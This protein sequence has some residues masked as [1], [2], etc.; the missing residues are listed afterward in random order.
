[1]KRDQ[2]LAAAIV[3]SLGARLD[4]IREIVGQGEVNYV[5]VARTSQGEWVVRVPRDPLD[6]DIYDKEAWC[7]GAAKRAGVS[8]PET[9]SFGA[10]ECVPF[11][12]QEFILGEL[13]DLRRSPALWQ[14][15]GEYAR[16]INEIEID[17]SAPKSLFPRFGRDLRSNW[18]QHIAYNL[19]ELNPS[20]RLLKLGAYE[21]TDRD[22]LYRTFEEL[23]VAVDR[24][25][26]TH[27]DLVP[28]NVILPPEGPPVVVDWG[29]ASV[30]PAPFTDYRRIW[31]DE[32]EEGFTAEDLHAFAEGYGIALS[33]LLP[34][35]KSMHLLSSI[36]VTR[37]AIGHRPDRIPLYAERARAA[38]TAARP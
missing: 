6:Q 36:D 18:R 28:K 8:A 9:I 22:F 1:M 37:W 3:K 7:A 5:F 31:Q 15:L 11:M 17:E 23:E 25:G 29:S 34:T 26:L 19:G 35:L 30:G 4:E 24:F 20:D 33:D 21:P 12:V 2:H 38:L 10:F 16:R 13:A 27:G 32:A 14:T